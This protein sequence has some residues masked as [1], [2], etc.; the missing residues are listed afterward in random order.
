MINVWVCCW[1]GKNVVLGLDNFEQKESEEPDS[2]V[3]SLRKFVYLALQN[4]PNILDALFVEKN[5]I[6]FI[7]DFGKELRNLRYD[8]LSKKVYKTYGGYAYSQ[9]KKMVAVT[10]KSE[11]KKLEGVNTRLTIL[12]K[13][14]NGCRIC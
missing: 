2:V 9:L 10:K 1:C 14:R 12:K 3:Y 4:N 7:N 11:G 8:F 6:I 13:K 5:H